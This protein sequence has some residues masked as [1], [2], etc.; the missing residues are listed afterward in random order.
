MNGRVDLH[1]HSDRSS[2]GDF[3][4]EELAGFAREHGLRAISIADHDTLAAYPEAVEAGRRAGVEVIPSMEATS[5]FDGREF[6]ILLPFV[7]WASPAARRIV[8]AQAERRK[9]ETAERVERIRRLGFDLTMDE[10][11]A[12]SNGAPVLGVKIAQILLEN[13]ANERRHALAP[14]YRP[15]N[16]PHAPYLF[17]KEYFAEGRP[18]YI[19]KRF[20]GSLEVLEAASAAGAAPVLAHPG[21]YF[22][23]TTAEDARALA[24]HGLLGLEVYNFYHTA[25]QTA[26]Y[27]SLA[28]ELGLVATAGSDFHG[29]IKPHVSFGSL[30]E[31]DYA[32]V[33]RLRERRGG[34]S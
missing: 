19:P 20:L 5:V 18:A 31:G 7:D 2:D 17:Y 14:F 24:E 23:R 10:V 34:A 16:R 33:E 9:A 28:E 12:K 25:E 15:E 1:V 32:M 29:R 8:E 4:P 21:A 26:F 27:R 22:Q 11:E 3:A 13:P 6:H 30:A